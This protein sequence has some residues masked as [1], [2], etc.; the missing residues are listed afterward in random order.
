[1]NVVPY[2][3]PIPMLDRLMA[4]ARQNPNAVAHVRRLAERYGPVAMAHVR[5][6]LDHAGYRAGRAVRDWIGR[7]VRPRRNQFMHNVR[8]ALGRQQR[9]R[10]LRD[11]HRTVRRYLENRRDAD[12]S[13]GSYRSSATFDGGSSQGR[14]GNVYAV[15]RGAGS[16][17]RRPFRTG[18][19]R[20]FP[21]Y[22]AIR[23]ELKSFDQALSATAIGNT[24]GLVA[25]PWGTINIG[26]QMN[27]RVGRKVLA[28]SV[29][30]AGLINST[31]AP[32]VGQAAD[33]VW[34]WVVLD[35]QP[36]AALAAPADVWSVTSA[37]RALRNLD[38][39]P[40]FKILKCLEIKIDYG[41][42]GVF[43]N[44]PF[45]LYMKFNIPVTWQGLVNGYPTTNNLLVFF[46]NANQNNTFLQVTMSERVRYYDN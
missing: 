11:G 44:V 20:N 42:S 22:K 35:R 30:L 5:Q 15:R 45:E 19:R 31:A 40:R 38:Q 4:V 32:G 46:G 24:I 6:F 39:G 13:R 25:A 7:H 28:K 16:R 17:R 37:E 10:A 34:M 43:I 23:P 1:M 26:S 33:T 14:R 18:G 12:G 21:M 2:F 36:N 8:T 9:V 41:Q 29:T 27:Q 3:S